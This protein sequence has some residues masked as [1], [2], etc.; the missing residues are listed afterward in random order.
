MSV[1]PCLAITGSDEVCNLNTLI[2]GMGNLRPRNPSV[3]PSWSLSLV[4]QVLADKPFEPLS[5]ISM[6]M[7]TLKTVVLIA[8]TSARRR[9]EIHALSAEPDRL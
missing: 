5:S 1:I 8:A 7:L 4:L 2:K 6:K 9:S 3:I